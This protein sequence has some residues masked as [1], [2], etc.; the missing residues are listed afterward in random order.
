MIT[1]P[2]P[3]FPAGA[4]FPLAAPPPEPVF[5]VALVAS[6]LVFQPPLPPPELPKP[7]VVPP[8]VPPPP[9]PA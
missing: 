7:N 4:K 6:K 3:P 5:A 1:M 9:P 2:E 8:S